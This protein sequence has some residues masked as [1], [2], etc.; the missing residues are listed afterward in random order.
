MMALF[1]TSCTR[2]EIESGQ[3]RGTDLDGDALLLQIGLA[4]VLAGIELHLDPR[5]GSEGGDARAMGH[6]RA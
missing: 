2:G 3:R 5:G 1:K 6:T 4:F